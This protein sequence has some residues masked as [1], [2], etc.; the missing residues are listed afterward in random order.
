VGYTISGCERNEIITELHIS[1]ITEC[2]EQYRINWKKE[3]LTG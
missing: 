1:Q 3:T 2:V